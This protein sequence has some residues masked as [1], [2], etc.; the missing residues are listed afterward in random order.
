VAQN[1]E[2]GTRIEPGRLD[3]EGRLYARTGALARGN[4]S[5]RGKPQRV[6]GRANPTAPGS[7]LL[8]RVR[9]R[10]DLW[11]TPGEAVERRT[12]AGSREKNSQEGIT[13]VAPEGGL[14]S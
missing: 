7:G 13:K 3:S 12:R 4:R 10:G 8:D 5:R 11:T 14:G 1:H 6:A 9:R 2:G